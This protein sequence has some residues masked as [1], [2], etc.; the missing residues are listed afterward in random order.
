MEGDSFVKD[1]MATMNITNYMDMVR[2]LEDKNL[3]NSIKNRKSDET[4]E[5][6]SEAKAAKFRCCLSFAN[7]LQM[8][9]GPITDGLVD[10]T[11]AS[12]DDFNNF[13]IINI[14]FVTYDDAAATERKV[15]REFQEAKNAAALAQATVQP[16][17]QGVPSVGA[18]AN[19][20][21]STA[22]T[23]NS[24][25]LEA[26]LKNIKMDASTY[27][28]LADDAAWHAF[29]QEWMA[30]CVLYKIKDVLD[31]NYIPP[32]DKVDLFKAHQ[33]FL[34]TVM[35]AKIKTTRGKEI[36]RHHVAN[37]NAQAAWKDLVEYYR[38][39][40]SILSKQRGDD[41][42]AK[43]N[44]AIPGDKLVRLTDE[45]SEWEKDYAEFIDVT[46]S[47][48]SPDEK[49]R[50]FERF[51]GEVSALK[52]VSTMHSMIA[53]VNQSNRRTTVTNPEATINLYKS[54]A[55]ELDIEWKKKAVEQRRR[56][57]NELSLVTHGTAHAPG[58]FYQVNVSQLIDAS[59]SDDHWYTAYL[60]SQGEV[61]SNRLSNRL[62]KRVW[63]SL[64]KE[65]QQI[66]DTLSPST[67]DRLDMPT[68][69]WTDEEWNSDLLINSLRR[70]DAI[71]LNQTSQLPPFSME[72]FMSQPDSPALK[73]PEE[74]NV[75]VLEARH[76]EI[77]DTD[78][79][80]ADDDDGGSSVVSNLL[81]S[82][83]DIRDAHGMILGMLS[84]ILLLSLKEMLRMIRG[85]MT[86]KG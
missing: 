81:S 33:S 18:T 64:T 39:P 38:G 22:S 78:G 68:D 4:D 79:D 35:M 13:Y 40:G 52:S 36:V 44:T 77:A 46:K 34:M 3:V 1:A 53:S 84:S 32:L 16:G 48:I 86:L 55:E 14:P 19:S 43:L 49:L 25:E 45:I 72:R 17:T 66:W 54:R 58:S 31:P 71:D 37:N 83:N 65:E 2:L 26:F 47:T 24:R 7:H 10:I 75:D 57:V 20:Q 69:D 60:A 23:A 21:T 85:Y 61:P 82:W 51:V 8:R 67:K 56:I 28:I 74:E 15:K 50:W 6:I 30:L 62:P 76:A 73:T 70:D 27:P 12:V 29:N 9:E 42:Y 11:E 59:V 41:L 80:F 5:D 63:D